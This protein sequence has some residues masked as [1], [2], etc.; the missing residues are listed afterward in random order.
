MKYSELEVKYLHDRLTPKELKALREEVNS[1]TDRDIE[2]AMNERWMKET[3]D[4]SAIDD[5]LTERMK[6]RIDSKTSVRPTVW[7]TPVKFLQIAAA[8]LILLFVST[9]IYF[10]RENK[11]LEMADVVIATEMGERASITLPD[12]SQV[13]VNSN[14]RLIYSPKLYNK[15]ERR[16]RFDGEGYFQVGKDSKRPFNIESKGLNVTVLG[17][18]FNLLARSD[19]ATA[20][21]MLE[22]G[23]VRFESSMTGNNVTL[24]PNQKAILN[25]ADGKI[26]VIPIDDIHKISAWRRGEM[27]FHNTPLKDALRT[28]EETYGIVIETDCGD[29]LND[30]FTGVIPN[31]S[32]NETLYIFEKS[33]H[34][35]ATLKNGTVFLKSA[36]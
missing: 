10:Y 33:Y 17:T 21:L 2:Q 25:Y 11:Q 27:V 30:P 13:A 1:M 29:C 36:N 24:K 34:F 9:T 19:D 22:K 18:T 8:A 4:V 12:G 15:S 35:K 20:E 3:P 6:R 26:T 14:S 5:A 28:V 16:I 32:L 23:S 31:Y 7:L